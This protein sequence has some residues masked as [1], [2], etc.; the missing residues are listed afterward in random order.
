MKGPLSWLWPRN[1]SL[2]QLIALMGG[3]G[4]VAATAFLWP[5][6]PL[7]RWSPPVAQ[8]AGVVALVFTVLL[9]LHWIGDRIKAA[10]EEREE[11]L[12]DKP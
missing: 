9:P 8:Y 10:I 5:N 7:A 11:R 2:P 12:R 3:C 6:N 4:L 1:W